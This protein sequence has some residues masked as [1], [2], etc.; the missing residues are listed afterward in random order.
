MRGFHEYLNWPSTSCLICAGTFCLSVQQWAGT[1]KP[2]VAHNWVSTGPV[3]ACH[4]L[5]TTGPVMAHQ[6]CASSGP[7][8]VYFWPSSG[9]VLV[10]HYRP[11]SDPVIVSQYWAISGPVLA[12]LWATSGLPV[13]AHYQTDKQKCT[14]PD[15]AASTRPVEVFS[16]TSYGPVLAQMENVYWAVFNKSWHPFCFSKKPVTSM[17]SDSNMSPRLRL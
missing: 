13:P 4:N 17:E 14:S 12:Q 16:L 9:N 2:D 15:E 1:C 8:V 3:L 6:I 10:S 11:C 7:D 5:I